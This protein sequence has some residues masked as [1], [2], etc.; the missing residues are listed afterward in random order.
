MT[1]YV[2]T[3]RALRDSH[4]EQTR[5]EASK[6]AAQ[7]ASHLKWVSNSVSSVSGADSNPTRTAFLQSF[8]HE[9]RTPITAVLG[10][11][12]LLRDDLT[13]A[14][15]HQS[16]VNKALRSL[17]ILLELVGMVLVSRDDGACLVPGFDSSGGPVSRTSD[18]SNRMS[19]KS[20]KKPSS[21]SR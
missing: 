15:G 6:N 2:K 16:L 3:K 21:S 10:I 1:S 7:E 5:L 9:V 11:C 18:A 14:L 19:S 4:L 12:E 13:L 8:S 17:E 20:R